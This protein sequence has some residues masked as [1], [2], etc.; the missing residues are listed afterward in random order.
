M[1]AI[2]L[3]CLPLL[4]FFRLVLSSH[5]NLFLAGTG[6][7]V[8]F[9]FSCKDN[10]RINTNPVELVWTFNTETEGWLGDFAEYPAGEEE[11]FDLYFGHDTLPEPLNPGQGA[12]KLSGMNNNN[13]LF[14]FVKKRIS[15]LEP[16]TVYY[17]NFIVEFATNEP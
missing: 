17:A 16:N 11:A 6:L 5:R 2:K 8:I 12:L 10:N 4:I 3:I 13:D 14:M 1:K 9:L 7:S 15:D